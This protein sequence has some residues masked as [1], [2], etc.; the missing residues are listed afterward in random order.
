MNGSLRSDA[1]GYSP[2]LKRGDLLV[3]AAI[4][5]SRL[6]GTDHHP[7]NGDVLGRFRVGPIRHLLGVTALRTAVQ[8]FG[9]DSHAPR[10][11]ENNTLY[12]VYS[13]A[14]S[15]EGAEAWKA[16][17]LS[18]S[19]L[20]TRS[21]IRFKVPL[22]HLATPRLRYCDRCN[23]GS[24][25]ERGISAWHVLHQV[26]AVDRCPFHGCPLSWHLQCTVRRGG[27]DHF[28]VH[29]PGEVEAAELDDLGALP[30]SEGYARYLKRWSEAY[31]A[32]LPAISAGQWISTVRRAIE[33]CGGQK[34]LAQKLEQHA[35]KTWCLSIKEISDRLSFEGAEQSVKLE[36]DLSS[37]AADIG[38]R[39]FVY[40]LLEDFCNV[41][42]S[43]D[44][45]LEIRLPFVKGNSDTPPSSALMEL[46]RIAVARG[47]PL[48]TAHALS[49]DISLEAAS[50]MSRV[51]PRS[52]ARFA[53]SL[54]QQL[55]EDLEQLHDWGS[56]SWLYH[57]LSR[58]RS[59]RSNDSSERLSIRR[60]ALK[61]ESEIRIRSVID[62]NCAPLLRIADLELDVS[63]A[64]AARAG[65]QLSLSPA[66]LSVLA[67]LMRESPKALSKEEIGSA[68]W[69]NLSHSA[70]RIYHIIYEIRKAVDAPGRTRLV[71]TA[72]RIGE[73]LP[74]RGYYLAPLPQDQVY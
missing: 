71:H 55:L 3:N 61:K 10:L 37:S 36:L 73:G 18:E 15:N 28:T 49:C 68:L 66:E 72:E 20:T 43:L 17:I 22:R 41:D 21:Q 45:Q 16:A 69:P 2:L 5:R 32:L 8:I 24:I 6:L 29:L 59:E 56:T 13:K 39:L 47:L 12:G 27:A 53:R 46:Q 44:M 31:D 19:L 9:S 33:D 11:L 52:I 74:S 30:E 38:R 34:V 51:G 62:T 50:F 42:G 54:S 64:S 23:E 7:A 65:R 58:R 4:W 40:S 57:E 14:M 67:L 60:L 63:T 70:D 25:A 1:I 26:P 48:V 35:L